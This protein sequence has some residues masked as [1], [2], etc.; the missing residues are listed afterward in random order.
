MA[1][2]RSLPILLWFMCLVQ[3]ASAQEPSRIISLAPSLTKNLHLLEAGDQL[4]G[5]TSY[6]V[7]QSGT[8]A[9]VVANAVQ[10]NY[11]KAVLLRPDLIITTDLTRDKTIRTFKKLGIPV[12]VFPNPESF[13]QICSQ[14]RELGTIIGREKQADWIIDRAK[15][16][17]RE[18]CSKVP[19]PAPE[20]SILVQIGANPLFGV[21]PGSFMN[22]YIGLAGLQN[23]LADLSFGNIT[24][25]TVLARN[26]DIVLI[27]LMG[28]VGEEE[29]KHWQQFGALSAVR[30]DQIYQ[31]GADDACSPTPLSF[32]KA[33]S[34]II[35]L[36]YPVNGH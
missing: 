9:E 28:N 14:F 21:T 10:V 27:V 31:I 8:K 3:A 24:L 20:R 6:C 4:V 17:L 36:I 35:E 13:E 16:E 1:L 33:L 18:I 29:K 5:C 11:E 26:P 2:F 32:V 19:E 30:N 34:E 15:A 22:D 23:I 12:K 7:L 25:E